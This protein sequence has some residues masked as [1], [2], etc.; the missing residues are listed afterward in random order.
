MQKLCKMATM[1]TI[2][3]LLN[4][5][6]IGGYEEEDIFDALMDWVK[7]EVDIWWEVADE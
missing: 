2:K 4:L 6:M 1:S 5:T 3:K 7:G